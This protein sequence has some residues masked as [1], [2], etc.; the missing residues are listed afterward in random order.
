MNAAGRDWNEVKLAE[1]PAL[2]LLRRLGY[3]YVSP[4]ALEAERESL[5]EVILTKRLAAALQHLNPWLSDDNL[6]KVIRAVTN[7]QAASLIEAS[8]KLHTLLAYGISVEQDLGYGKKGQTVRL[9]DFDNPT[10]N[11]LLVTRQFRVH[12]TKKHIIADA[13]IFVNGVP[14]VVIECKS[15]TLGERWSEEAIEQ[16]LRYQEISDQY[17]DLG[18]PKLFETTQIIVATCG[19][20]A[21]YGTVTTTPRFF[22]E[23][24]R[25]LP[26]GVRG[27]GGR[28]GSAA[29]AAGGPLPRAAD[30]REPA[31]HR[32]QLHRVRARRS[33]GADAAEGLSVPAVRR[34]Q[35]GD[36]SGENGEAT[37][38]A[39]RRRLAHARLR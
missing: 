14:L 5:K 37:D 36:R 26:E 27:A 28:A 30:A 3:E 1:D 38:R 31:R 18:A 4:E 22:A 16:V 7:L 13:V 19:Q 10:R 17:R 29:D 35:Q 24:K 8:E 9:F 6:Q 39:G 32:P 11:E 23:W 15:P 21:V 20:A 25:S 33:V 12:G 34:G 2:E